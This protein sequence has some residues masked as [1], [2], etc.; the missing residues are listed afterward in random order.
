MNDILQAALEIQAFCH[1]RRW[2]MCLIG[3]LAVLRWGEPRTTRDVDISL[4]AGF[5]TERDYIHPL[6]SHFRPRISG[7]G[8]FA[9][10]NRVLL[11]NASNGTPIDVGLAGI[12][13]E[14]EVIER[15]S[16]FSFAPE[17]TLVTCSAEDLVVL[18]AFAGR[19]RDWLD[20]RGIIEAQK[21]Q[22]EWDYIE[23]QLAPL[24]ELKEDFEALPRLRQ[25]RG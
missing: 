12:R 1:E 18:K 11:I 3:G 17:A 21:D 13:Y 23:R 2:R 14:E 25:L 20:V 4:L 24:C 15:A 10:Q 8:E 16:P 5:G 6:L 22:L 9:L 19:E 7:A